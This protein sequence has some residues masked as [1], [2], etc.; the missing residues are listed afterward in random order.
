VSTV[1][2]E[3][4]NRRFIGAGSRDLAQR[5]RKPINSFIRR[6]NNRAT[7]RRGKLYSVRFL[8]GPS[9]RNVADYV[10]IP[11]EEER[12]GRSPSASK[13]YKGELSKR[14]WI[15]VKGSFRTRETAV[16]CNERVG[17]ISVQCRLSTGDDKNSTI[18]IRS[19]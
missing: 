11:S 8:C 19:G 2:R 9:K 3:C 5:S 4:T 14:K 13:Y 10:E 18:K 17:R 7:A 15:P 16:S 6:V 1:C 12:R